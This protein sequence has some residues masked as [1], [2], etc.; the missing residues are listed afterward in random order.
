MEENLSPLIETHPR[1][2]G[3]KYELTAPKSSEQNG[4]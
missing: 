3:V 1:A 4:V 2:E